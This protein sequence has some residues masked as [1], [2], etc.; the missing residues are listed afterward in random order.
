MHGGLFKG[1]CVGS[2]ANISRVPYDVLLRNDI[3]SS[4]PPFKGVHG[5]ICEVPGRQ[6]GYMRI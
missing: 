4:D 1:L 3:P 2:S 5:I 6:G